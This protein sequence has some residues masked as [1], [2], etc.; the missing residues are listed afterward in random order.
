MPERIVVTALGS[1]GDLAP[2]LALAVG[3]KARNHDVV[4]A[5]SEACRDRVVG[6]GLRFHPIGPHE[7]PAQFLVP[8]DHPDRETA[9]LIRH[10]L[11]P[12]IRR[13]YDD[14][15]TAVQGAALLVT[16]MLSFAGP[17]VA[18]STGIRWVSAVFQPLAFFSAFDPVVLRNPFSRSGLGAAD[19]ATHRRLLQSGRHAA[20]SWAEPVRTLRAELGLPPGSNPIYDDHHSPSLVLAMFSTRFAAPQ[21]DWPPQTRVTGFAF[22]D[23]TRGEGALPQRLQQFLDAGPPPVVFTLGSHAPFDTGDFFAKS[24]DTARLLGC[25]AVLLGQGTPAV[26]ATRRLPPAVARMIVA[27]DYAPYAAVFPRAALVVHHGG[28]G[29]IALA[30]RAGRAMLCVPHGFDQPDN[31]LRA[32]RLG[33]ARVVAHHRYTPLVATAELSRLLSD[34]RFALAA[35]TLERVIAREDGVHAACDAVED[36]MAAAVPRSERHRR[37][38]MTC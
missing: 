30:L 4:V 7:V 36:C 12:Q 18:A 29:T 31:S 15:K 20:Y 22:D 23:D 14:L 28:I 5:T 38:T 11:F 13:S 1:L 26:L 10:L 3:L 8:S 2:F 37:G 16:Q 35:R 32:E 24:V 9:A 27:F 17:I 25:R 34:P 19:H 33:C 21:P 6:R